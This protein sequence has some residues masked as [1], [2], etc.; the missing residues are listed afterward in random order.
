MTGEDGVPNLAAIG[1]LQ[2]ELTRM[3]HELRRKT[4][5]ISVLEHEQSE[6]SKRVT[7][8]QESILERDKSLDALDRKCVDSEL[9]AQKAQRS[10]AKFPVLHQST[11]T[12]RISIHPLP[13]S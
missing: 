11:C 8:A 12:V 1:E 9:A 2:E 3:K 7:L 13:I 5:H 6:L 10:V 4:A